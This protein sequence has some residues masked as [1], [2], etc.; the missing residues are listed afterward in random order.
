MRE[1]RGMAGRERR[2][3]D[4]AARVL[5]SFFLL[6][7][8]LGS[9][10]LS[11]PVSSRN[12]ES[13]G[14]MTAVF[15][16]T[17]ATCVTGLSLVDSYSQW[18]AFG[19][20]VLLGLIQI[21]GLGYMAFV[22]VFYFLLRRRIGLRER[23]VLQQ[24]MAL[25]ELKGVVRL[26]RLMLAG[27]FLVEGTGALILTLRFLM[28]YPLKKALWL[29][30]F[31][32]VS[33]FCN[34]GFDILGFITP[35]ASLVAYRGDVAINLTLTALIVIGGLGFFV[36]NDLLM[37]RQKNHR[38]RVHTRLVLWTTAILLVGGTLAIL[39]LEWNNPATLGGLPVGTKILAAFFQ[40][41]TTRTAGFAA[42]D[43]GSLTGSGK[44]VSM[45]LMLVGGSSGSTAGGIKTVS[46]ALLFLMSY[47]VL[48]NHKET[49][50]FGRRI[51]QQ[52]MASAASIALLVSGLGLMGGM[53]LSTTNG[54]ALSDCLYE[55]ISA[56][57]TVGLSTGITAGLNLGSKILLIVYMFFGRVGIMTIS[58]AFMTKIP[59]D[60]AV[61]HP[62][63]RVLIG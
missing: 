35:G 8:F 15:T 29:G 34:A 11:L 2:K 14:A 20:V 4:H 7:I 59:P 58:F 24:A 13:C 52:Q 56:I 38:L 21:G 51:P 32:A 31:H 23:L 37:L 19:Q 60:N 16:A 48:R 3:P 10:L 22:S 1:N 62:D 36:W 30:V 17:S 5:I 47:S 40:S 54:L 39:T 43:Q 55:S 57:C 49:V 61:R 53:I 26:V 45:L 42:V 6:V 44:L 41:G 9:V 25:D 28:E 33:A 46:V 50:L 27:T 63:A 18:S 12:G